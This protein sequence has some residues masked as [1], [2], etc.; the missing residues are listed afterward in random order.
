MKLNN[1]EC[2]D[3]TQAKFMTAFSKCSFF[4]NENSSE[5]YIKGLFKKEPI[6]GFALKEYNINRNNYA[7]V[8]IS[9]PENFLCIHYKEGKI[10]YEIMSTKNSHLTYHG[11]QLNKK[12]ITGEIHIRNNNDVI[13]K[14]QKDKLEAPLANS[15]NILFYPLPICR[16]E[17]SDTVPKIE[18]EKDINNYFEIFNEE[19]FFNVIEVHMS[20]RGFIKKLLNVDESLPS[21]LYSLFMGSNMH[22]FTKKVIDRRPGKFPQVLIVQTKSYE[23][24]LIAGHEY[25]NPIFNKNKLHHFFTK[26]YYKNIADRFIV[27]N[28]SGVNKNGFFITKHIQKTAIDKAIKISSIMDDKK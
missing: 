5:N 10:I 25:R 11:K 22:T 8:I 27:Y 3:Y 6:F 14:D 9:F 15:S 21:E 19:S 7:D 18:L 16:I 24:I 2:F 28:K 12:K 1:G 13:F 23:L 17:I 4:F 26:D 20:K